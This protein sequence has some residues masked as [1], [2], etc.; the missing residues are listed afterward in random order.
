M[1][2]QER[3]G[4]AETSAAPSVEELYETSF[5]IIAAAGSAKS[6]YLEAL[7]AAKQG[8]AEAA[9]RAIIEGDDAAA[10]GHE[11]H[12]ELIRREAEGSPIQMNFILTHA[13]DQLLG[14]ELVKILALELIEL[15]EARN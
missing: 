15:Y 11:A 12:A 3:A 2:E 10:M 13:E 9:Q 1:S 7:A 5:Q 14:A 8:N 4:M 6:S